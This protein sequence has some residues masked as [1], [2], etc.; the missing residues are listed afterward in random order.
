MFDSVTWCVL[1]CFVILC[2]WLTATKLQ[3]GA[4]DYGTSGLWAK[5]DNIYCIT[6][7]WAPARKHDAIT[8][9][10]RVGIEAHV[11][12]Y[13]GKLEKNGHKGA[14][15]AHKAVAI[16]AKENH[17]SRVL[18]FED[19]FSFTENFVSSFADYLQ[20]LHLFL[21]REF[22][23]FLLLFIHMPTEKLLTELFSPRLNHMHF[24]QCLCI[25]LP[26]SALQREKIE[27]VI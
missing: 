5:F 23:S 8:Q 27:I 2:T 1:L 25:I 12:F 19:D 16:D 3:L 24:F 22:Q 7:D 17:F 18:V 20:S 11:T 9:F 26:T 15:A 13:Y 21:D 14:W 10:R 4:A 6:G